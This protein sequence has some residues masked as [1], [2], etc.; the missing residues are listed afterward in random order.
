VID[1][2]TCDL[3][4][5]G[6]GIN[7]AGIARDAAGRGLSV[8]LCEQ[9]DFASGTSSMSSKLIHGGLRYLEQWE[10][11]LV[12][13]ALHEREVLLKIAPHLVRPMRFVMPH[14]A[15]LRPAWMIR[16]GLWLYDHL[17]GHVSLEK[18]CRVNLRGTAIGEPLRDEFVT[19]FAYSDT[20]TDDA[21]LVI[22]TLQSARNH[23]AE[24]L[25][26]TRFVGAKREAGQWVAPL[27]DVT[28]RAQRVVQART[29]VNAA[30]PWVK[31]V[32][33]LTG[34]ATK[35]RVGVR[36]V[37]GSHI[38]VPRLYAGDHAYLLQNTD[39]RIVF[40]L[41]YERDFTMVGTTDVAIDSL[42][43]GWQCS[44][45][46]AEYLCAAVNRYVRRPI[47]PDDVVWSFAGIRPLHDDGSA[48][49]AAV[50][51]DYSLLVEEEGGAP[52]LNVLGGKIT[53]H[54]K[55]A[56]AVLDKLQPWLRH[57]RGSW[58]G[59]EALPDRPC[60]D[61]ADAGEDLGGGL[62]Q[63]EVD[64]L[65]AEEWACTAEDILWRRTKAG[66]HM[67]PAQREKFAQSFAG[68]AR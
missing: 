12:A 24:L 27:E 55:L 6:G 43:Q 58:T 21:R 37:K 62:G 1:A 57:T 45:A 50:T 39:R 44:A 18:S 5:V 67:T 30:G 68:C 54:R 46:E 38:V 11:R 42:E 48:N 61:S 2:T 49:P 35:G 36:L 14:S 20:A 31:T 28:T 60:F 26:R 22:A 34:D 40:M 59:D 8:L 25:P 7:G 9:D 47:A 66:L 19:G 10:F 17:G 41:P 4:I 16:I 63:S 65:V 33:D 32:H 51:R 3:L 23:G 29:L 56:E 13:E 52:L 15:A 64:H 53:T